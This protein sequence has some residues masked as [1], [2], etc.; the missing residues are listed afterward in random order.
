M[1]LC[2]ILRCFDTRTTLG[3][4]A[5][6]LWMT[7]AVL[8]FYGPL[9]FPVKLDAP[10]SINELGDAIAGFAAPLAF[11]WLVLGYFQQGE[12]LNL[13]RL[14]IKKLATET[15]AQR[16]ALELSAG[17]ARKDTLIRSHE[18]LCRQMEQLA[19]Q[20]VEPLSRPVRDANRVVVVERLDL[21][22]HHDL[23]PE[24]LCTIVAR[25]ITVHRPDQISP[26]INTV[27]RLSDKMEAC[28]KEFEAIIKI[29]DEI[30][31]GPNSLRRVLLIGN[32]AVLYSA[33]CQLKGRGEVAP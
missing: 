32:H 5:S 16:I 10:K 4:A 12:E 27:P 22:E 13:Q 6:I 21:S 20:M 7:F 33:I 29:A 17:L 14:E 25:Y 23:T 24:R 11:L 18:L 19:R 2:G 8:C 31:D 28:C 9:W 1:R 30:S 3:V 26:R 15:E